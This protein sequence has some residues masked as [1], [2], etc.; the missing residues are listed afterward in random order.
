VKFGRREISEIVR[1][2]ADKKNKISPG[3]PAVATARTA[4]KMY[5]GQPPTQSA[6]DFIQIGSLSAE[7]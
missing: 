4:P 2:L 6:S 5:Q 3:S 7:L 1:Y